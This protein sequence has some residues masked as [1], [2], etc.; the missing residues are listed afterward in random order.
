M[1]ARVMSGE[2]T[3]D[4][5]ETFVSMIRDQ[6]IPRAK[7]LAGFKGGYWL[8][9]RSTGKVLGVTLY[10]T[11]AALKASEAQANRIREEASRGAGLP[12]PTF[13]EYEVIATT[14]VAD[15]LAA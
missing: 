7:A 9:D 15:R 6:V 5:V 4:D 10:E 13:Q 8:A 12:E 2:L 11:E 14:E 1:F 3:P